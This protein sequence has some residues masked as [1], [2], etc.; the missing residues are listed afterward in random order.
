MSDSHIMDGVKRASTVGV[1]V[2]E[3]CGDVHIIMLDNDK[4]PFAE[5]GLPL[6]VLHAFIAELQRAEEQALTKTQCEGRA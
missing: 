1:A 2:C 6:R 4:K 3:S 5:A